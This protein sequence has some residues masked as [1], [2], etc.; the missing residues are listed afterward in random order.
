MRD[1]S[2]QLFQGNCTLIYGGPNKRKISY[3]YLLSTFLRPG[4]AVKA[5]S[6]NVK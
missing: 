2:E 5:V 6:V 3:T 4:I 1:G